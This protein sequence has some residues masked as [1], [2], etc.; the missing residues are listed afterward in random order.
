M[1]KKPIRR[2]EPTARHQRFPRM[3]NRAVLAVDLNIS[4]LLA[5]LQTSVLRCTAPVRHATV[6][7]AATKR[8]GLT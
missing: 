7:E 4:C 6:T 5:G 3:G 1:R 2:R 8:R